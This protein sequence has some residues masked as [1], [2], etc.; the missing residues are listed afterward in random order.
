MPHLAQHSRS[1]LACLQDFAIVIHCL[2]S[3]KS[4]PSPFGITLLHF[5]RPIEDEQL[6]TAKTTI[7][8]R[9]VRIRCNPTHL[10]MLARL[11]VVVHIQHGSGVRRHAILRFACLNINMQRLRAFPRLGHLKQFHHDRATIVIDPRCVLAV[12]RIAHV[13]ALGEC[14]ELVLE[15]TFE[16]EEFFAADMFMF[17]E[18]R[19]GLVL[20]DGRGA[21][22]LITDAIQ[23][24]P[25][26]T[27]GWRGNVLGGIELNGCERFEVG[28]DLHV[29]CFV[30]YA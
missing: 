4:Q 7:V 28:V 14:A 2:C 21:G 20:D 16:H 18:F 19:V 13:G 11:V 12:D 25:V 5:Q 30:N 1:V 3:W 29:G 6:F 17:G 23:H 9:Q 24:E 22:L 26:D 8:P 15:G 10:H 27:V